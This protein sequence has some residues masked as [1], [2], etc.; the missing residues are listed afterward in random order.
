MRSLGGGEFAVGLQRAALCGD[1]FD[2]ARQL[3]PH[4]RALVLRAAGEQ[5]PEWHF[6]VCG[7]REAVHAAKQS[8]RGWTV[9]ED[10]VGDLEHYLVDRIL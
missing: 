10:D 9:S 8:V 7:D 6:L 4:Q 5:L 1:L 2:A 3:Q